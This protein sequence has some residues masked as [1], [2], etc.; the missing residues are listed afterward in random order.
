MSKVETSPRPGV[1]AKIPHELYNELQRVKEATGKSESQLLNEAIAAYLGIASPA[2]IPDR[3]SQVEA[4]LAELQAEV[5]G[6]LGK[7]QRLAR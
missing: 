2:T 7:L 5:K 1:G 4:S 3:L 6:L